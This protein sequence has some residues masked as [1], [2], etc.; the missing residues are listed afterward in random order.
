MGARILKISEYHEFVLNTSFDYIRDKSRRYDVS[1]HGLVGE[2]GSL[3]SAVKKQM[4]PSDRD[5]GQQVDSFY[6]SDEIIERLGDIL[7]YCFSYSYAH[8]NERFFNIFLHDISKL[9]NEIGADSERART[10]E[11]H[12][13]SDI[14]ESFLKKAETYEKEKS[15]QDDFGAYQSTAYLTARTEKLDLL[16]VC[17]AVLWQLGAELLRANNLPQIELDLNR[18]LRDRDDVND[19]LGEIVWH[20]AAVATFYQVSMNKVIDENVRKVSFRME[21]GEPTS[22]HDECADPEFRLP[23]KIIVSVLTVSKGKS[24]MYWKG[25]QLGDDLTDNSYRED[26]YRFHDVLHLAVLAKLGWSPVFRKLFGRKR[27]YDPKI[28]EIEDGA[29]ALIIEEA[30]IK[31]IHSEGTRIASN[32]GPITSEAMQLIERADEITFGFL[33]SIRDLLKGLEVHANKYWEWEDA[34]MEGHRIFYELRKEEQGTIT[35][36]LQERMIDFT[37]HVQLDPIGNLPV[38]GSSDI[39]TD[40]PIMQDVEGSIE[41]Y[42]TEEEKNGLV[43]AEDRTFAVACAIAVKKAVLVAMGIGS[44]TQGQYRELEVVLS[45]DSEVSIKATGKI[46]EAMWDRKVLCFKVT[47]SRNQHSV[48]CEAIGVTARLDQDVT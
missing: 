14:K 3:I 23:R 7:W 44:P 38:N 37:P 12:L 32:R 45:D 39:E 11:L 17:L 34:I 18:T 24:R 19:V 41:C 21:R 4:P 46:Q 36:D 8:N 35:I 16:R 43:S 42:L 29:R 47:L 22:L 33:R 28:D 5:D 40:G 15:L 30:I 13:G 9:T 10:I 25:K 31:L 1:C 48:S 20:V 2:I 6:A 26:G 27:R